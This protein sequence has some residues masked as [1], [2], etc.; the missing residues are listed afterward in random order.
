MKFSCYQMHCKKK[1]L[2]ISPILLET[3]LE[4]HEAACIYHQLEE[5]EDAL[6]VIDLYANNIWH[7][8][9]TSHN[10]IMVEDIMK[11][12]EELF[13]IH[14]ELYYKLKTFIVKYDIK[15]PTSVSDLYKL[16]LHIY[17]FASIRPL[18][19]WKK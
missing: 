9:Q 2:D 14:Q 10:N 5:I 1:Y 6:K 16:I 13:H 4:Y 19:K 7:R 15:M 18:P 8:L 17:S 3:K 11:R 12:T